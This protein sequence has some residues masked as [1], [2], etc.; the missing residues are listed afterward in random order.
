M[1]IEMVRVKIVAN[2]A[3]RLMPVRLLFGILMI[4]SSTP[5]MVTGT[6]IGAVDGDI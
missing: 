4:L 2:M 6:V 5:P 3:V 1:M